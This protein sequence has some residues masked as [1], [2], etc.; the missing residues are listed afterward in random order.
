MMRFERRHSIQG[1]DINQI[2]VIDSWESKAS[3]R[4]FSI[5]SLFTSQRLCWIRSNR[6][7]SLKRYQQHG[8]QGDGQ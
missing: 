1:M 4:D 3:Y 2:H 7:Q 5:H 8:D 6:S